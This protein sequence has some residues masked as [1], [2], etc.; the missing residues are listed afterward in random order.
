MKI[1]F[2]G[3]GN[4]GAPMSQNLVAAGHSVTGFDPNVS[5]LAGGALAGS[6]TDCVADAEVV[7]T[8]LPNGSILRSVYE[9]AVTAAKAG[10]LFIDCST[11]DVKSA[12][13]VAG[14][15]A[16]AGH[17][18]V[19]APVSGGTAGARAGTLTFMVGGSDDAIDASMPLLSVMG[20]KIVR[21]GPSGS[22]Q[23]AKICNNMILGA[24]MI[25]TCE[26]FVLADG[27]SLDRQALF[28]VVSGSSGQSWS[29]NTY[30]PV[31]DVG[32]ETPADNDYVPGFAAALMLKDLELSQQAAWVS[33]SATPMGARAAEI[34]RDFVATGAGDRDFSAIIESLRNMEAIG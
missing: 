5:E 15:A 1:G 33:G 8:M 11:V 24:T 12:R 13:A 20:G 22:G 16:E 7:V 29:M 4:M 34:Y 25:A 3:L 32:P 18:P 31:P 28:D 17:R 23:A 19:D 2:V 30:C 14:L 9:D 21:C 10:T 27:L 6:L 26:A